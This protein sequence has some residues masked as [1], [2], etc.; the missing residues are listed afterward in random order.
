M[1]VLESV[2]EL[3]KHQYTPQRTIYIAVGHDEEISGFSGAKKTA[4]ILQVCIAFSTPENGVTIKQTQLDHLNIICKICIYRR[5][6]PCA[7]YFEAR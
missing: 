3:L 7:L 2:E 1:A 6:A 4:D 5:Y